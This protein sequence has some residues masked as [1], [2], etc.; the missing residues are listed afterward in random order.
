[1][2]IKKFS[3]VKHGFKFPSEPEYWLSGGMCLSAL[4]NFK[5]K[6]TVP[7]QTD[8][9]Y[10]SLPLWNELI[11]YQ[12]KSILPV[13]HDVIKWTNKTDSQLKI[14]AGAEYKKLLKNIQRKKSALVC[15]IRV[16][17]GGEPLHNQ[18]IVVYALS[19][20]GQ[21]ATIKIYDP[22]YPGDETVRFSVELTINNTV[23]TL[24]NQT[25][26]ETIRGFFVLDVKP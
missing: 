5:I 13:M 21:T 14:L 8:I 1:M 12:Y 23:K 7:A 17:P 18:F 9:K 24:H 2:P 20:S 11:K 3:P 6:R 16:P 4:R 10:I 15:L 25:T 22:Y 26:E 19:V